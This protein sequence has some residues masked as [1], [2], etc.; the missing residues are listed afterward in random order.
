MF[1]SKSLALYTVASCTGSPQLMTA[2]ISI[3]KQ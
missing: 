3:A 2:I 1:N